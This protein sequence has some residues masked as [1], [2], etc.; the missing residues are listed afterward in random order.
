MK[1][2]MRK[3][4]MG[5]SENLLTPESL[6]GLKEIFNSKGGKNQNKVCF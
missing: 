6:A 1:E 5:L 4:S 3:F 2:L